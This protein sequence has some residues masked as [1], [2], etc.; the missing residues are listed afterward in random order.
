MI[1]PKCEEG[2]LKK[3]TFKHTLRQGLFCDFCG[4]MWFDG[5]DISELT[6]HAMRSYS[7]EDYEEY[8]IDV[9]EDKN[10]ETEPVIPIK[11]K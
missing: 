7:H 11:Y 3:M 1:C 8:P 6:G 4:S 9:D 10:R 5:E 2:K